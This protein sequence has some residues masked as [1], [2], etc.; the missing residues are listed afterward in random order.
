MSKK[1]IWVSKNVVCATV[2][3]KKNTE[4]RASVWIKND[5]CKDYSSIQSKLKNLKF[6]MERV[7]T[8]KEEPHH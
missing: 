2:L 6:T 8:Y 3:S 7:K 1:L 4:F 5:N